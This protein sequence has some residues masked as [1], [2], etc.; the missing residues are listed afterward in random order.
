MVQ[1]YSSNFL[2]LLKFVTSV[3]F[4]SNL[5]QHVDNPKISSFQFSIA[6]SCHINNQRF[7]EI[8]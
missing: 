2:D 8:Y 6:P 5:Q 3:S 4:P 1:K 7:S